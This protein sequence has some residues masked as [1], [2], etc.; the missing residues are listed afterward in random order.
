M[1]L[2]PGF[3]VSP[4]D[5]CRI[6]DSSEGLIANA[7]GVASSGESRSWS[8]RTSHGYL[9]HSKLVFDHSRERTVSSGLIRCVVDDSRIVSFFS[10]ASNYFVDSNNVGV[11]VDCLP[12]WLL[13]NVISLHLFL[14]VVWLPIAFLLCCFHRVQRDLHSAFVF[15]IIG[16]QAS[17]LLELREGEH[18]EVSSLLLTSTIRTVFWVSIG[19]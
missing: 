7:C 14:S 5:I 11:S 1:S 18:K 19:C 16:V 17:I 4:L 10:C 9:P 8:T 2:R 6:Q 3:L 15:C 13:S 12:F